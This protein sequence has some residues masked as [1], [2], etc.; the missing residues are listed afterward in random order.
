VMM[1]LAHDVSSL[2]QRSRLTDSGNFYL[3]EP[4]LA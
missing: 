4:E 2:L 1:M 3:F